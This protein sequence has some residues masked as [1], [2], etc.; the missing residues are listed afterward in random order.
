MRRESCTQSKDRLHC[1]DSVT[2]GQ[3]LAVNEAMTPEAGEESGT[4]PQA[5]T[6]LR[7]DFSPCDECERRGRRTTCLEHGAGATQELCDA[8]PAFPTSLCLNVLIQ[9][10][11]A[12]VEATLQVLMRLKRV[13][14]HRT[15]GDG[16]AEHTAGMAWAR[17]P[18]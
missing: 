18:V 2:R 11:G 13:S 12:T 14:T 6:S 16:D 1:S 17:I 9:E 15:L 3:S 8:Q 4:A 7:S 10:M 5:A